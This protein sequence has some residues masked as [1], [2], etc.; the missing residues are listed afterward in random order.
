MLLFSHLAQGQ[1]AAGHV[2]KSDEM[3]AW[4]HKLLAFLAFLSLLSL[5]SRLQNRVKCWPDMHWP[6]AFHKGGVTP[7]PL[8][9]A[10]KGPTEA[11]FAI[12]HYCNLQPS[13]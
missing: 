8:A 7:M 13:V 3:L 12:G 5:K 11:A 10:T 2:A 1:G 9:M 6:L 4:L